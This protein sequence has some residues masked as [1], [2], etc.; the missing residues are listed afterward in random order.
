[1]VAVVG[2]AAD[3]ARAVGLGK[4]R[5]LNGREVR[6]FFHHFVFCRAT[7]APARPRQWRAGGGVRGGAQLV[8]WLEERRAGSRQ[9]KKGATAGCLMS[10]P[11]MG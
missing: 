2:A 10:Q 3:G 6:F 5:A 4:K 11:V 8:L 1:M 9:K 7:P